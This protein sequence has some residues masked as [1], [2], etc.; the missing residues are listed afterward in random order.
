MRYIASKCLST[1]L[2]SNFSYVVL[3]NYT[4]SP[5]NIAPNQK[6]KLVFVTSLLSEKK[7]NYKEI[8]YRFIYQK[9]VSSTYLRVDSEI[10]LHAVYLKND[11]NDTVIFPEF[12]WGS[13]FCCPYCWCLNNGFT[14][15]LP[16]LMSFFCLFKNIIFLFP[17]YIRK[18]SITN[19]FPWN[20]SLRVC[21][22]E[23]SAK[24]MMFIIITLV[25]KCWIKKTSNVLTY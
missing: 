25:A 18:V 10:Y 7:S 13:S 21:F 6:P 2:N 20:T 16:F 8:K 9:A 19:Y 5:L 22:W 11:K 15:W 24:I 1:V 3:N 12:L 17:M 23:N 4:L 14:F